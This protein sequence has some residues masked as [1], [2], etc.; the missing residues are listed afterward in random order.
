M[1][2]LMPNLGI[3]RGQRERVL[4]TVERKTTGSTSRTR[5]VVERERLFELFGGIR[6]GG[7]FS[8]ECDK[9]V[10]NFKVCYCVIV[11]LME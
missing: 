7:V 9:I 5:W 11:V 10:E 4:R 1:V 8:L 6:G 3:W 2:A